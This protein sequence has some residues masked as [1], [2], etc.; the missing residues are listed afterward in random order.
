MS[1]PPWN[2]PSYW[3]SMS[4]QM[5]KLVDDVQDVST[6]AVMLRIVDEY[7]QRAEEAEPAR[8]VRH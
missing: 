7:N 2:S 5:R 6:K 4:D 8:A 3:R 1:S